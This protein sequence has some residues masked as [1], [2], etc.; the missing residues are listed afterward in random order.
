MVPLF[1]VPF[2]SCS[3]GFLCVVENL[4]S[5]C[6]R[7]GYVIYYFPL[8]IPT[9]RS[10]D[11][12]EGEASVAE[13]EVITEMMPPQEGKVAGKRRVVVYSAPFPVRITSH[14]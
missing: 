12:S 11:V 5:F 6:A 3:D 7:N 1:R 10:I 14:R 13:Y 8:T 2:Q 4:E 9:S